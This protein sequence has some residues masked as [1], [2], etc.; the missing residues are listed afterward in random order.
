MI[1]KSVNISNIFLQKLG[2]YENNRYYVLTIRAF[3][4]RPIG[5]LNKLYGMSLYDKLKLKKIYQI[6]CD[7]HDRKFCRKSYN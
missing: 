7:T 6:F 1:L 5:K 2:Q 4:F 3:D